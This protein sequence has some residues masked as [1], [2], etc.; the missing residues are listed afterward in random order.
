MLRPLIGL[1]KEE[2]IRT[3]REIGTFET[4]ILPYPDCCTLFAA[5]HPI[6]R[7]DIAHMKAALNTLSADGLIDEA[8]QGNAPGSEVLSPFSL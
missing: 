8:V 4:S 7:P 5:K 2:I 1:D 6:L 3:A